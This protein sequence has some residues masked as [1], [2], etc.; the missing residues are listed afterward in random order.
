M[1]IRRMQNV[2]DCILDQE[3]VTKLLQ[4]EKEEK[5]EENRLLKTDHERVSRNHQFLKFNNAKEAKLR[6]ALELTLTKERE[7]NRRFEEL[8]QCL[9]HQDVLI[10]ELKVSLRAMMEKLRPIK[11]I[12]TPSDHSLTPIQSPSK[13]FNSLKIRDDQQVASS[14]V[15]DAKHFISKLTK[16]KE[17]VQ[18]HTAP[19]GRVKPLMLRLFKERRLPPDSIRV[20]LAQSNIGSHIQ[21][22]DAIESDQPGFTSRDML[23]SRAE[24]IA[25]KS[26]KNKG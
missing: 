10:S 12:E 6:E 22:L 5:V 11:L 19:I 8:D 20:E 2:V 1:W 9:Q 13:T 24:E 3:D 16:M 21:I 14:L 7:E 26:K 25:A 15:D 4:K 23:K 18:N 17:I